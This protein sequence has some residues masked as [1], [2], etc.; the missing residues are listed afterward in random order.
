MDI[1]G[2]NDFHTKDTAYDFS[3]KC[4]TK[5]REV[6]PKNAITLNLHCN[7]TENFFQ[8]RDVTSRINVG[9]ERSDGL[10]PIDPS[11]FQVL[12]VQSRCSIKQFVLENALIF[13][14]GR[15][16]YEFTKPEVVSHK[17]EVV[18]VDRATGDMFTGREAAEMI[19][20][21]SSLSSLDSRIQLNFFNF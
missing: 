15:G 2:P 5:M 11:R 9:N 13:K 4:L 3:L 7:F 19:G 17:K 20:G 1:Y 12:H 8:G 21:I 18:L 6:T 14:T 16:F 10:V